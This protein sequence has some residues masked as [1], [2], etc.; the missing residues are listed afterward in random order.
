LT[1]PGAL[2][3]DPEGTCNFQ[4]RNREQ[5]DDQREVEPTCRF[6]SFLQVFQQ[7]VYVFV[8]QHFS[9]IEPEAVWSTDWQLQTH[10]RYRYRTRH[11]FRERLFAQTAALWVW[12]WSSA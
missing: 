4:R 10:M 9:N 11:R 1:R 3:V 7:E 5:C 12:G 2:P 6:L 8:A